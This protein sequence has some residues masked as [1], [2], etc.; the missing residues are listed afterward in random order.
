MSAFV[1]T[2]PSPGQEQCQSLS[3]HPYHTLMQR[4][5]CRTGPCCLHPLTRRLRQEDRRWA[6]LVGVEA[7]FQL[8]GGR[9][10]ARSLGGLARFAQAPLPQDHCPA[11]PF[12]SSLGSVGPAH[13]PMPLAWE[14]PSQF[15]KNELPRHKGHLFPKCSPSLIPLQPVPQMPPTICSVLVL[16]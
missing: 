2:K 8:R 10:Q 12:P 1:I 4:A 9:R 3:F 14:N 16:L 13:S 6:W 11:R 7:V 15:K 5:S